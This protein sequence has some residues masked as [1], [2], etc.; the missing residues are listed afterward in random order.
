MPFSRQG[1]VAAACAAPVSASAAI[2]AASS[3]QAR[4]AVG[5]D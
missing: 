2:E 5:E 3:S 4:L 1:P